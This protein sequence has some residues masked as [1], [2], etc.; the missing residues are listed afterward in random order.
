MNRHSSTYA[1]KPENI[2][3]A[4]PGSYPRILIAD[5][6]LA[7]EQAW[8]STAH[9]VGTISYL[10]PEA[11]QALARKDATYVGPPADCWSLG[12][13]MYVMLRWVRPG[14]LQLGIIDLAISV[15]SILSI[16]TVLIPNSQLHTTMTT[17]AAITR[18]G[19]AMTW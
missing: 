16:T 14:L 11:I 4:T 7:R 10:P 12:V 6:G 15:V 17:T 18:R 19:I 13:V 3:L 2:L 8:Q 1:L 5:F 9:I